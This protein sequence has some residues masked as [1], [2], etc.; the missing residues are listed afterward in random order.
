MSEICKK[1]GL[2]KDLCTCEL[3]TKEKEKIS[4]FCVKRRYGKTIT[5]V[6]GLSKDLNAKDILKE[7]KTKLACGGTLKGN[8]I[9]LQGNHVG[10]AKQ[11]MIKLG[12]QEEQIEVR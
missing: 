3:I 6:S 5:I 9:E 4:I 2:P 8:E 10:R 1:C 11:V 7:L 12:F